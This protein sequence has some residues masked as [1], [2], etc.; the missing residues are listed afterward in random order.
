MEWDLLRL[1][2]PLP[3][4]REQDRWE[5]REVLDQNELDQNELHQEVRLVV[6]RL[7]M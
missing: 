5:D 3:F 4:P 7:L 6:R 2:P 1:S